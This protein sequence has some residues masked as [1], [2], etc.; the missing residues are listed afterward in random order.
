MLIRAALVVL[1]TQALIVGTAA[2]TTSDTPTT[3]TAAVI[4]AANAIRRRVG[5]FCLINVP[6]W[7]EAALSTVSTPRKT[8]TQGSL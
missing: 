8:A 6:P 3:R 5:D 4:N 1:S 2:L 7:F